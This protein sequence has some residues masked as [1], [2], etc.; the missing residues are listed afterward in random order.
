MPT[1]DAVNPLW[2]TR[3][4]SFTILNA[5][6]TK[7]FRNWSVYVGAENITDFRQKNPIISSENP[8]GDDFDA[9]MVWGPTMGRKFYAG[10]RY[11][12]GK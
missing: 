9:T 4:D 10:L 2:D 5:Q 1:P 11:T 7:N 6:V 8:F 12:I 3:F